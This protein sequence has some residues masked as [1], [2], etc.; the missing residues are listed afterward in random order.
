V[1]LDFRAF[2]SFGRAATLKESPKP[3]VTVAGAKGTWSDADQTFTAAPDQTFSVGTIKAKWVGDQ[4]GVCRVRVYPKPPS[5]WIL[6]TC[7]LTARH[8]AGLT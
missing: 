5:R 3:Q 7:R 4:E 8:R 1:K 6:R 2:T